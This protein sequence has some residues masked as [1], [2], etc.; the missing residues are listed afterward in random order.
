MSFAPQHKS[1]GEVVTI[2]IWFEASLIILSRLQFYWARLL[3]A[4]SRSVKGLKMSRS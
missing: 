3:D 2:I 4:D 1:L